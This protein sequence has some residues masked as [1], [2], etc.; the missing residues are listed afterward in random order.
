MKTSYSITALSLFLSVSSSLSN[1][2]E[3]CFGREEVATKLD[4]FNSVVTTNTL[5][6]PGGIIKYEDIGFV[7]DRKVDL[8]VSVVEGTT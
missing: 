2:D 8:V 4:F 7:R 3:N 6:E 5:Q 1:N